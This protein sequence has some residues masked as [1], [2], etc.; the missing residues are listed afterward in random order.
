MSYD[1]TVRI[2][3]WP[4]DGD[5]ALTRALAELGVT[6]TLPATGSLRTHGCGWFPLAMAFDDRALAALG[7]PP[8]WRTPVET[9][10]EL[11]VRDGRA[12]FFSA[13]SRTGVG[14]AQVVALAL[15]LV[16]R[17]TLEDPQLPLTHSV[18]ALAPALARIRAALPPGWRFAD[19]CDFP[20]GAPPFTAF[21]E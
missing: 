11:D 7:A 10:F 14:P 18:E 13:R 21:A 2:P 17:G 9:G 1:L 20:A 8:N 19:V 5:A 6:L 12:A 4:A 3:A 16:T 15:A